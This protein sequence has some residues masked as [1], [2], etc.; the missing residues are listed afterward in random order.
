L[1][2][3]PLKCA[4]FVS[5]GGCGVSLQSWFGVGGG[6]VSGDWFLVHYD[7]NASLSIGGC[8]YFAGFGLVAW[9]RVHTYFLS[10]GGS[11]LLAVLT[12]SGYLA[13]GWLVISGTRPWA[14]VSWLI[15]GLLFVWL[16]AHSVFGPS[17]GLQLWC[18]PPPKL[19]HS[20]AIEYM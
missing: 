8:C 12:C 7:L 16:F 3:R 6:Y 9:F 15:G 17:H 13:D 18:C 5:V 19:F 10:I 14:A 20:G 4:A 11:S 1:G 2:E